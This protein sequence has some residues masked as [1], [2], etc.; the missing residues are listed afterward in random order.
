MLCCVLPAVRVWNQLPSETSSL[1]KKTNKTFAFFLPPGGHHKAV[2]SNLQDSKLPAWV[3]H[4]VKGYIS[5][6]T[7][8]VSNYWLSRWMPSIVWPAQ[9]CPLYILYIWRV[10]Q[11]SPGHAMELLQK[12]IIARSGKSWWSSF[13]Q[14]FLGSAPWSRISHTMSV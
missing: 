3:A 14:E 1:K 2:L 9:V 6:V 7:A 12:R 5:T 8:P 13:P 10:K 4:I 11:W